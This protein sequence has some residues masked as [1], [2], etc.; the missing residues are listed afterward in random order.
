MNLSEIQ[1]I[2]L[3]L[4]IN[5]EDLSGITRKDKIRELLILLQLRHSISQLIEAC[6]NYRNDISWS[7]F[8]INENLLTDKL[9]SFDISLFDWKQDPQ[10]ACEQIRICKECKTTENRLVHLLGEAEFETNDSCKKYKYCKRCDAKEF[11]SEVHNWSN[12][13][14]E[15]PTSCVEYRFCLRCHKK[16]R[17]EE[18]IHNWGNWEHLSPTDCYL[19]RKCQHCPK[20]DKSEAE[21]HQWSEWQKTPGQV[22]QMKKCRHCSRYFLDVTGK[23]E[24]YANWTNS[25][26]YWVL[27]INQDNNRIEG[28]LIS[29]FGDQNQQ[30]V[31]QK[32]TG[33][34]E[35]EK[36]S[37][38]CTEGEILTRTNEKYYLDL[39][40]GNL[41][42]DGKIIVGV[43]FDGFSNGSISLKSV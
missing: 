19:V 38:K 33:I 34:I 31:Q 24:G 13:Q 3:I 30:R 8:Q 20:I 1:D 12:W 11:V 41:S 16:E 14:Y 5:Y 39:F 7:E 43:V 6:K 42:P 2:C 17:K 37:F 22:R 27:Q 36:I 35:K 9:Q 40:T 15:S 28:T 18:E 32:L 26:N 21:K 23:W 10:K 29:S 25:K 4:Q